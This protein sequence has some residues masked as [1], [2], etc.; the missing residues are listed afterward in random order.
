MQDTIKIEHSDI[1]KL[2]SKIRRILRY[3]MIRVSQSHGFT[4]PQLMVIKFIAENQ[5]VTL[6]DLS[7]E[8][9]LGNSTTSGI[10]DRL[11]KQGVL[12]RERSE[13]DRRMVYITLTQRTQELAESINSS[14]EMFFKNIFSK[15]SEEDKTQMCESLQKLYTVLSENLPGK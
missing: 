11:V 9:G 10:I 1:L 2:I 4:A 14:K 6:S 5:P 8:I 7:K 13:A 3:E 15:I 12:N